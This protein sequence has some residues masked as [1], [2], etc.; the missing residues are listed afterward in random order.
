MKPSPEYDE[1][2][3]KRLY[4]GLL[5]KRGSAFFCVTVDEG[6]PHAEIAERQCG[7]FPDCETQVFD[8]KEIAGSFRF[9]SEF[10]RT[11]VRDGARI[12][13]LANFQM[14]CGDMPDAE[15]FQVLNLSR[16]VLAQL[17]AVLV[18]MMPLYFRMQIARNAPDFNSFFA[19]RADFSPEDTENEKFGQANPGIGGEASRDLLK[20]Y[21]EQWGV[22]ADR[23]GR[24]A[25]DTLLIMLKLNISA[26]TLSSAERN[27]FYGLF[28]K[29]LPLYADGLDSPL[30]DIADIHCSQGDYSKAL[31]WYGR[32]YSE[33]SSSLGELH[34]ATGA[35]R[36]R[37]EKT[38]AKAAMGGS[39]ERWLQD[40]IRFSDDS[41]AGIRRNL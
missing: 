22:L 34:A 31:V 16:D 23:G 1:L 7:R 5:H 9:S 12:V 15:F 4:Q 25:F 39:F 27:R 35:V 28:E 37:A 32:S 24:Q 38:Y 13:F 17:P 36:D 29:L 6:I 40:Q 21:E 8:F 18:F 3:F 10:I 19:F 2:E 30:T 20:Y 14:A 41:G 11:S 26:K 33:L